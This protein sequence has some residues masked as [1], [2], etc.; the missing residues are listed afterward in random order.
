MVAV[1]A[2][3]RLSTRSSLLGE[4][5]SKRP[6]RS[7][8]CGAVGQGDGAAQLCGDGVTNGDSI[9]VQAHGAVQQLGAIEVSGLGD[10]VDFLQQLVH[11]VLE[12]ATLGAGVGAVGRLGGQLNHTVQHSV[13]LVQVALGGLNQADAI[14]GVGAG[15]L[16]T[17]NLGLHLLADGQACGVITG[18]VDPEAGGQLLQRLC[19]S[20]VVHAQ[21]TVRVECHCV[22][23][24]DHSHCNTSIQPLPSS[25]VQ[26]RTYEA[27]GRSK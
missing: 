5:A 19:D 9:G 10:S 16:Q 27:G 23:S 25:G 8:C 18:P 2:V 12:G 3:N 24:Y 14:L 17:G 26:F 20:R 6:V 21:L 4:I 13:D 7:S 15:G 1:G 11:L 22:G